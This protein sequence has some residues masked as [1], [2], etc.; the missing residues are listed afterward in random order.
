MSQVSDF[1]RFMRDVRAEAGRIA[2]P[3]W[4]ATRQMTIMVFI[5]VVLVALYL[6]GVDMLIGAGMAALLGL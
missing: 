3:T 4:A 2:W 5:L 1:M 6:L